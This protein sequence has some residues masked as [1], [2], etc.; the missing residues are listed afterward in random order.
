MTDKGIKL[1]AERIKRREEK[2]LRLKKFLA[3]QQEAAHRLTCVA[4]RVRF[5]LASGQATMETLPKEDLKALTD[6]FEFL[7]VGSM[8]D[9]VG[10]GEDGKK[11]K[12]NFH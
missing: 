12:A 11:E 4:C 1:A 10:P 6:K 9:A 2:R 7:G 8:F 3:R 5:M